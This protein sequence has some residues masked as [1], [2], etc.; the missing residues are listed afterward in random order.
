MTEDA[1]SL[2]IM[3]V[4]LFLSVADAHV[5]EWFLFTKQSH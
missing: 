3:W 1:S 5:R 2:T 4:N